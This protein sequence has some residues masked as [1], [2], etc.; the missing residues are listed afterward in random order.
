MR[1]AANGLEFEVEIDEPAPATLREGVEPALLKK[2]VAK[3]NAVEKAFTTA[4]SD[5]AN[6]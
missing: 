5:W 4:W 3:S 1:V 2:I 6:G